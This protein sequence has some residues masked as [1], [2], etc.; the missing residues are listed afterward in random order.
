[1]TRSYIL[2][3]HLCSR[4]WRQIY[5]QC[6]PTRYISHVLSMDFNDSLKP[7]PGNYATYKIAERVLSEGFVTGGDPL[8]MLNGKPREHIPAAWVSLQEVNDTVV[9]IPY[10][11]IGA[12]SLKHDRSAG[13]TSTLLTLVSS[14]CFVG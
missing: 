8:R 13:R 12:S 11:Q 4:F 10:N 1:M 5:G 6:S 3:A 14:K 2:R 9:E 7:P